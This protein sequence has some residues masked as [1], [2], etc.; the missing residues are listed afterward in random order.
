MM[1]IRCWFNIFYVDLISYYKML[2]WKR[3]SRSFLELPPKKWAK[4]KFLTHVKTHA[5]HFD[6]RNPCKNYDPRK[7]LTHAPH[8]IIGPTWP[9]H[10]RN[11]RD[12]A[13][14]KNHHKQNEGTGML[15]LEYLIK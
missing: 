11:P 2:L 3:Q 1:L 4:Q 10:P 14:S 5:K 15:I 8:V 9:M 12:L 7:M 6:P 13:D